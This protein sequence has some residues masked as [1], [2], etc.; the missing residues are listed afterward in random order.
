MLED[1]KG[2][3]VQELPSVLWPFRTTPCLSTCETQYSL[4]YGTETIIPLEVGLPTLRTAQLDIGGI[5][6]TMDEVLDFAE[7]RREITLLHLT[8]Y[9]NALSK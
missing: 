3:W 4:T 9:Q 5:E 8:N 6:A 1:A 2:K 7:S